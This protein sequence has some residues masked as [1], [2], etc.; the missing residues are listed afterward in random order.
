M[1]NKSTGPTEQNVSGDENAVA[2]AGLCSRTDCTALH[3]IAWLKA[4]NDCKS[5]KEK[6][7]QNKQNLLSAF[8]GRLGSRLIT[9]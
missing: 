1:S 3:D 2:G 5:K 6:K 4:S 9:C 7:K 8:A